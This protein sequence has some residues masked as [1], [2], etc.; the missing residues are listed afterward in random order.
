MLVRIEKE[1]K[2]ATAFRKIES[3]RI[4][5]FIDLLRMTAR[6]ELIK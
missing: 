5:K 4:Y 6:I 1:R 3:K 2:F